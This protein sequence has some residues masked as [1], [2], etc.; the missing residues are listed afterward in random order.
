M[1]EKIE[2]CVFIAKV[3][4]NNMI[5]DINKFKNVLKNNMNIDIKTT[6]KENIQDKNNT[7]SENLSEK[8]NNIGV[9]TN[10]KSG[11]DNFKSSIISNILVFSICSSLVIFSEMMSF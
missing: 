11:F 8:L 7:I 2:F 9:P 5:D 3:I 4:N 1:D 10:I 6:Y